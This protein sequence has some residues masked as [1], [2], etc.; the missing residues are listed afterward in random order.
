MRC[1][2]GVRVTAV[3]IAALLLLAACLDDARIKAH[4]E[5][6]RLRDELRR[7]RESHPVDV[8]EGFERLLAGRDADLAA[9]RHANVYR[10]PVREPGK[11]DGGAAC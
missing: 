10:L 4:A 1:D 5:V 3:V 6:G 2:G 7:E 11:W 9:L 8:V